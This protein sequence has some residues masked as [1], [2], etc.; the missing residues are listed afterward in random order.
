ME[1]GAKQSL[2]RSSTLHYCGAVKQ[3]GQ[4]H[5]TTSHDTSQ[6]QSL[7]ARRHART[8]SA[9]RIATR[10]QVAHP[11]RQMD[12]TKVH[13]ANTASCTCTSLRATIRTLAIVS[14]DKL[15]HTHRRINIRFPNSD[16]HRNLL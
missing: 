16:A 1:V 12:P 13:A 10:R 11:Q 3:P 8:L 14:Y 9:A 2:Q 7:T 6:R 15:R 5:L 4:Q